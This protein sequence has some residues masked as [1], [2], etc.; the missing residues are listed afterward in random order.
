MFKMVGPPVPL[1]E[2]NAVTKTSG[3]RLYE[4]SEGR[5]YPSIT[6][7]TSHKKKDS[8]LKWRKRVGEEKANKISSQASNRGN[9][10]HGMVECYLKNEGLPKDETHPLASY[11]FRSAIETLDRINN[12]H[13]LEAPLFSDHLR[14]AGRVDCIAEFDGELAV[15]DFKTSTKPKQ[16]SWIENYFVQEAA[17]AA[18]YYER[19]GV[20]VQKVVTIIAVEDGTM[21]VIEKRNLNELYKLLQEYIHDF[22]TSYR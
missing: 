18:M 1:T 17:Y 21:Q 15:I 14:I 20:E 6:T 16:E 5:W 22:N 8:I 4:V 7:I 11:L 19:C 12:I 2:L 10:F 13:L 3:M 9:K